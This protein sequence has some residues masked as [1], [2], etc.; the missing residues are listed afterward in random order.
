MVGKIGVVNQPI[1]IVGTGPT[2]F[3]DIFASQITEICCPALNRVV[4]SP[5]KGTGGQDDNRNQKASQ[6]AYERPGSYVRYLHECNL[7]VRSENYDV[8]LRNI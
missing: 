6:P 4:G 2:T 8:S 7:G 5:F 1:A 3:P